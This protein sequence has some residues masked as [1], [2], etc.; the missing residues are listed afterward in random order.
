MNVQK[1][2]QKSIEAVQA[3][4]SL[5]VEHN[6]PEVRQE[7]LLAALLGQQDGLIGSLLAGMGVDVRAMAGACA[8]A[9]ERLPG[10]SGSTAENVYLN[11]ELDAALTAAEKRA[12]KMGDAYVSVEHLFLGLLEKPSA[13]TKKLFQAHSVT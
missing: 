9:V 1:L 12:E 4:H 7:H 10:V 8:A 2:T 6:N 5:A 3:A 11:R 13:E